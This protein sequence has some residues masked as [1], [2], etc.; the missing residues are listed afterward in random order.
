MPFLGDSKAH[1]VSVRS[2][3]QTSWSILKQGYCRGLGKSTKISTKDFQRMRHMSLSGNAGNPFVSPANEI[4]SWL[5]ISEQTCRQRLLDSAC[6]CEWDGV[7]R[8]FPCHSTI[9]N[10]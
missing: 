5:V 4:G 2:L 10:P 3:P 9:L 8:I 1:V 6:L 7:E